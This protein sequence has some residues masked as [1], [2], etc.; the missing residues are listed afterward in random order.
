MRYCVTETHCH[1][2][3]ALLL[4]TVHIGPWPCGQGVQ[5]ELA[6]DGTKADRRSTGR[7]SARAIARG[8]GMLHR[9]ARNTVHGQ[10]AARSQM[11]QRGC[12]DECFDTSRATQ[13]CVACSPFVWAVACRPYAPGPGRAGSRGTPAGPGPAGQGLPCLAGRARSRRWHGS[14]PWRCYEAKKIDL[15]AIG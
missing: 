7:C 12:R 3:T 8:H 15:R 13:A 10:L 2:S 5:C 1:R 9:D 6:R 11:H 14:A 4:G